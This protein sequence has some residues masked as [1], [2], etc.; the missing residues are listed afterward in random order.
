MA[1]IGP[2]DA[3]S[4]R[5]RAAQLV[6]R[7][8]EVLRAGRHD[9]AL[10]VVGTAIGWVS[11][12]FPF[13]RDQGLYHY[14]AREWIYN[15]SLPYRDVLDHKT[16]GIYVLNAIAILLFGKTMWG[17]RA[18]D[19]VG[20][21]LVSLVA[22]SFAAPRGEAPAP[23]VCGATIIGTNLLY[24]GHLDFWNSAQSELW[25]SLLGLASVAAVRRLARDHVAFAVGGLAAG[26]AMV[27]K[28][29]SGWFV[30]V[31]FGVLVIRLLERRERLAKRAVQAV[32]LFGVGSAVV[33]ASVIGYFAMH[34]NALGDM[35]DV[36]VGANA[37]YVKHETDVHSLGDAL[38]KLW[39]LLR[40]FNPV[41]TITVLGGVCTLALGLA[42]GDRPL[43]DR[44]IL[45][46]VLFLAGVLAVSMQKKFFLLHYVATLGPYGVLVANLAATCHER[47]PL[48]RGRAVASVVLLVAL[49]GAYSASGEPVERYRKETAQTVAYLRG[50]IDDEQF[51]ETFGMGGYYSWPDSRKVGLW[52]REHAAPNDFVAVRAF[53]P[54]IYGVSGHRYS[55]RFF[56]TL[57]LTSQSRAYK[58]EQWLDEDRGVLLTQPPRFVV[59]LTAARDGIDSP[60]YFRELGYHECLVVNGFT[61]LERN[62]RWS[63]R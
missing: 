18:V 22:A 55:G 59:A 24:F 31:A 17:I 8:G 21:L 16:P 5:S 62:P 27:M 23:G 53:E 32:A 4:S 49:L 61:V 60:Q 11:L 47:L 28:P 33:P 54:Q 29:P 52:L 25:Y 48:L 14:V 36:V 26:A 42:R 63:G 20:V 51:A 13:G 45:A 57:F 15:G 6:H 7:I 37:Y 3:S 46:L 40:Y 9:I 12:F 35:I 39:V 58:R 1:G 44:S 30:L 50:R 38:E 34:D 43:R 56:W 41:G 2:A 10:G 19:M